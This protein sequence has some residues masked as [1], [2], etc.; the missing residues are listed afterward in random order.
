MA[1]PQ[2]IIA[3]ELDAG[4]GSRGSPSAPERSRLMRPGEFWMLVRLAIPWVILLL[5][6]LVLAGIGL[7]ALVMR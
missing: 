2:G 6:V 4:G 1:F 7:W 5:V 3:Q